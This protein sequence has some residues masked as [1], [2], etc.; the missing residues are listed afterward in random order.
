MVLDAHVHVAKDIDSA[1]RYF[2]NRYYD[3]AFIEKIYEIGQVYL[4]TE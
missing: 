4:T 2:R 1:D 3:D